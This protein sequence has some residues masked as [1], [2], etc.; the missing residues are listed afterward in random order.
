MQKTVIKNGLI[1]KKTE[2]GYITEQADIS[3]IGNTISLETDALIDND[4]QIV[5][6][7][8]KLI[9]P[10]L[11]NL[12]THFYMTAM[13]NFA[14]DLAF[15]DWLFGKIMPAEDKLSHEFA[16]YSCLLGAMEMIGTGT[17]CFMDMHMFKGQSCKAVEQSGM[18]A[19][20]GRCVV[21]EDLYAHRFNEALEE[22]AE[23]ESDRI[24]FVLSPHAIYSCSTKLLQQVRDEAK[25]RNMLKQ[26]HAS[27]SANEIKNSI[28]DFGKRPIEY[29]ADMGFLDDK[30]LLAHCVRVNDGEMDIIKAK[31]SSVVTNPASN[32]K[33]GNGFAPVPTMLNKGIN[34]CLGTDSAASNN[35]LNMFREMGI[36]SLI[37]KGVNEDS[38]LLPSNTV[39]DTAT[40]NPAKA[41]KME[42]KL[43]EIKDGAIAD[44]VFLDLN[45]ISLFPHNNIVS[46]LSNSAN[47]SEVSSV[48]IDGKWVM[49]NN[50]YL[51]IDKEKVLY[52]VDRLANKFLR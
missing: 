13:R 34:V 7:K 22:M 3:V 43:G 44:L 28:K 16:Y 51:T 52:E 17:T 36:F 31:G 32:M 8:D 26:I 11:I 18:R 1:L 14:D 41:V 15:D 2:N 49:R 19:F 37:H 29:L 21:G 47:G 50:E 42:G 33:L 46:S 38:T 48:M 20:I 4:T 25:K 5:D 23:Y 45:K 27:E 12:H 35:T 39:I 9:I 10:G 6:A 40:V 24:K 30:T